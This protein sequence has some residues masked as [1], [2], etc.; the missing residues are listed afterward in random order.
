[1][2]YKFTSNEDRL[3]LLKIIRKF[4]EKEIVLIR[5]EMMMNQENRPGQILQ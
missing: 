2:A 5:A 1:M 4:I 3:E